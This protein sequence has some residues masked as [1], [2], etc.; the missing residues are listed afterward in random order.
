M[1]FVNIYLKR[2]LF[3]LF[4][5][6]EKL[7]I[8]QSVKWLIDSWFWMDWIIVWHPFNLRCSLPIGSFCQSDPKH[9]FCVEER[10]YL[11]CAQLSA[12]VS[13]RPPAPVDST[14]YPSIVSFKLPCQ[15][16]RNVPHHKDFPDLLDPPISQLTPT[17][18]QT[19]GRMLV[20]GGGGEHRHGNADVKDHICALP[21]TL[22]SAEQARSGPSQS[23]L[24]DPLHILFWSTCSRKKK[25]AKDTF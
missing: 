6:T 15:S 9:G 4:R 10:L 17:G 2:W 19:P 13:T 7:I 16:N 5:F 1:L 25:E 12:A 3:F 24:L 18:T 23:V 8:I 11:L 22:R 14:A 20:Q 21:N